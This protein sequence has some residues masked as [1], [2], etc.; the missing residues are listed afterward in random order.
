LPGQIAPPL[1]QPIA[2]PRELLLLAQ[3]LLTG[4]DPLVVRDDLVLFHCHT[5]NCFTFDAPSGSAAAASCRSQRGV[6]AA[7]SAPGPPARRRADRT[8]AANTC[9][10]G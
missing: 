2:Q 6:S 8:A 3:K 7:V 9:C 1:A 5:S 10:S 4:C